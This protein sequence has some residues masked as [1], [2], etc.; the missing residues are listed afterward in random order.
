MPVITL[1]TDFG[2]A[3]EYV[4]VMKGVMLS[5]CPSVTAIDIS[6][7]IE[8]QNIQQAAYLI[9][10]YFHFFPENSIH[11]IVVDPGVGSQRSIL[12][13]YCRK[14]FFIAPDNGVL[15]LLL[16][17]QKSDTIIR[18]DNSRY[19]IQ[20]L[21]ATFHGRDI[22]AALGGHMA[23]GTKLE[24]LGARIGRQDIV[25]LTDLACQVSKNGDL[26]G[27]IVS[28]DRFGNLVTNIDTIRLDVFC[29]SDASKQPQ[30]HIGSHTISGLARTYAD[31][32]PQA[33]LALIGSRGYMEIALNCGSAE[34]QLKA[35]KGDLV[36]VRL[37]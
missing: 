22:L 5:I 8:P 3:D 37:V 19:F 10:G 27:K 17:E 23:C 14:H 20:P 36:S 24:T 25:Q 13:V 30:I 6:H 4:G 32:A 2:T 34:N 9:P 7:Q 33:P 31:A 18:V 28:I 21:S 29:Q 35:C 12:A 16:S 11:I 1:L 26:V 15:T